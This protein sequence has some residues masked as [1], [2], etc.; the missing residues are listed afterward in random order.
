MINEIAL[1]EA[2]EKI[3]IEMN[4]LREEIKS[5]NNKIEELSSAE[6][7][8]VIKKVTDINQDIE[9]KDQEGYY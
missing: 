6:K 9:S 2:F 1:K 8:E 7:V 4:L 5:L 3:K